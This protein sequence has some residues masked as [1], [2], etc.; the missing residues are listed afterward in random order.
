MREDYADH[1]RGMLGYINWH[2]CTRAEAAARLNQYEVKTPD[3]GTW[4]ADTLEAY[5]VQQGIQPGIPDLS[6]FVAP[7][8]MAAWNPRSVLRCVERGW[9]R[10]QAA[11]RH[12]IRQDSA[13]REMTI[14][15]T[16]DFAAHPWQPDVYE[17]WF[18]YAR[19]FRTH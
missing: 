16:R 2:E 8:P 6:G 13:V 10:D 12:A 4:N 11:L 14:T 17:F 1:V 18:N 9:R 7:P 3:G 5:I 19:Y 15:L